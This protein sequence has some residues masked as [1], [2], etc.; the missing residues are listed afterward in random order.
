[1]ILQAFAKVLFCYLNDKWGGLHQSILALC[2][3]VDNRY[4]VDL[5]EI[6]AMVANHHQ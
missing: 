3:V 5:R 1:M 6:Q 4:G 2:L